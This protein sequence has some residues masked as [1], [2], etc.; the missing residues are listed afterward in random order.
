MHD[1]KQ[2]HSRFLQECPDISDERWRA[3][4]A[5]VEELG[6]HAS[7]ATLQMLLE[8]ISSLN[9]KASARGD[10][11]GAALLELPA[12]L[13]WRLSVYL[14]DAAAVI[15]EARRPES[16]E[17]GWDEQVDAYRALWD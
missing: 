8:E 4:M 6:R 12:I 5:Q 15:E 14:R 11:P 3:L 1:L 13:V 16:M 9:Q 17:G 2:L 7:T 10:S